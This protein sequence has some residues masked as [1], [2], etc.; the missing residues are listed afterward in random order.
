MSEATKTHR[1]ISV[2]QTEYQQ[3][4]TKL[5]HL[6]YQIDA[7][8]R[9]CDLIISSLRDLNLEAVATQAA[10]AEAA[11]SEGEVK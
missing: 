4:C 7:H 1:E 11:K 10:S 2:I 3:L 9:D 5:G 6:N 8:K